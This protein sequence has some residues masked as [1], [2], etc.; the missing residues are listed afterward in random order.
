[1]RRLNVRL[2]LWLCA[3]TLLTTA[4]VFGAHYL[5]TGRIAQGLLAQADRAEEQGKFDTAVRYLDRYLGF[6]PKDTDQLARVGRL[7]AENPKDIDP[8]APDYASKLVKAGKNR[9]RAADVLTR[10][11]VFRPDH[12]DGRRLLARVHLEIGQPEKA[13]EA[14]TALQKALPDDGE[15]L[16]LL[17]DC[18]AAQKEYA[19]AAEAYL[20]AI[21]AAPTRREAY[22]RLAW[23]LESKPEARAGAGGKTSEE[24]LDLLVSRNA[25]EYRAYLARWAFREK[26]LGAAAKVSAEAAADVRKAVQLAPEE[27]DV[28][29]AA[30]LLHQREDDLQAARARLVEGRKL[31]PK[32]ARMVQGLFR[33]EIQAAGGLPEQIVAGRAKAVAVLTEGLQTLPSH[34]RLL[35]DLTNLLLDGGKTDEAVEQIGKLAKTNPAPETVQYL[36]ARVAIARRR[37]A[38]AAQLLQ[39]T[40]PSLEASGAELLQQ[41][42]LLLAECYAQVDEPAARLAALDRAAKRSGT[43]ATTR[44][45]LAAS[46]WGAGY[47]GRAI[48]ELRQAMALPDAPATGWADLAQM[49]VVR[50][51]QLPQ[52]QRNWQEVEDALDR[53][54]RANIPP[55]ELVALRAEVLRLQGRAEDARKLLTAERDRDPTKVEPWAALAAAEDRARRPDEAWKLLTEAEAK[56]GDVAALRLAKARHLADRGGDTARQGLP[57]LAAGAEKFDEA[58]RAALWR[59]LT[60]AYA[61]AGLMPEARQ[62]WEKYAT[63]PGRAD[64]LRV[65]MVRFDL[66][67]R[68]GD[69]KA[70]P[71][72]VADLKRIEGAGGALWQYGEA[73]QLIRTAR[74]EEVG[75]TENLEKAR[76]LLEQV[77]AA[78]PNWPQVYLARAELEDSRGNPEQAI[79]SYRRAVEL[80]ERSPQVVRGLVELLYQ[81]KRYDE[82][83]KEVRRM[84]EQ[85]PLTAEM[86]RLA[87]RVAVARNDFTQA[88]D[89][90]DAVADNSTDYRDHLWHGQVLSAAGQSDEAGKKL[91]RATELGPTVPETWVSLVRHLVATEQ[92]GPARAALTEAKAKLPEEQRTLALAQCHEL[93]GEAKEAEALYEAAQKARP[94]D[95]AVLRAVVGFAIRERHPDS[96][97]RLLK[98]VEER[99][100]PASDADVAWARRGLAVLLSAKGDQVDYVRSLE[101][102]GVRIDD[103]G[104][105]VE[106][107]PGSVPTSEELRA[108]AQILGARPSR[109]YRTAA[110][111]ALDELARRKDLAA[112]D[113]YL[114]AQLFDADGQSA[115]ARTLLGS[116]VASHKTRA[117]YLAAY[118]QMLV[119]QGRAAEAEPVV[120]SLEKLEQA[121]AQPVGAFGSVDLRVYLLEA[122]QE[123]RKAVELLRARAARPDAKPDDTLALIAGLARTGRTQEALDLCEKAWTTLPQGAVGGAALAVLRAG[124]PTAEQYARVDGWLQGAAAK[125]AKGVMFLLQRADLMD[126][127]GKFDRAEELHRQVLARDPRSP[128]A[129]NNLAWLL[130][131]KPGAAAEGLQ[132]IER[133]IQA[134]GPLPE[135]LDTRSSVY[136][137]MGRAKDA[138]AD[139][140]RAGEDAS[141]PSRQFRLAAAYHAANDRQAAKD[142][143]QKA[144]D[145]GLKPEHLHPVEQAA[146]RK[147]TEDLKQ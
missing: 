5:Q 21:Q 133:A 76:G 113:Q 10:L 31:H 56:T 20:K 140:K 38:E 73:V 87:S 57:K 93:L 25:G 138:I 126:M 79:A 65:Q 131:Q 92:T 54:A 137:A 75:R 14:L 49:L 122:R 101:L 102:V 64:D 29:L 41:V 61:L 97:I 119:R 37:W 43:R 145:G 91:R 42:D 77:A 67:L 44:L 27:A 105:P 78:R 60:E 7:L 118:G 116:L 106:R 117:F 52:G 71:E 83:E 115:K 120:E 23:L 84:Q 94:N 51:L 18:H 22:V 3:A 146:Y 95:V 123:G 124:K 30:A 134:H 96:A 28:L 103:R 108:R 147:V 81:R 144:T 13:L 17:G 50:N 59:G 100:V 107:Q 127:Q 8:A 70:L 46:L 48:D 33:L 69:L 74:A 143:L 19:K 26:K 66:A 135:Y 86:R 121:R 45:A 109:T 98:L 53:A 128:V 139:L 141:T 47:Y 40:R 39:L 55:A 125:D 12:N 110:L 114:Q 34:P 9:R 68:A 1:M 58:E 82:A 63:M 132:L 89:F 4:S 80:G 2:A 99:K 72:R 85:A 111:A 32:D 36:Q 129:L 35:W 90:L 24:I 6:V 104:Q 88:R 15:A 142:A 112:E 62:A 16:E 136:L 130:A 11:L